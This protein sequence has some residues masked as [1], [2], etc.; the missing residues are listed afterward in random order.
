LW[1]VVGLGNPGKYY[2]NTRHNA[3]FTFVKQIARSWNVKLRKKKYLA[4]TAEVEKEN[5]KVLL[6]L[7]Q[8]YMNRSGYSVREV[9]DGTGISPEQLIV[10]YDDLDIPLGEIRIRKEGGPGTHKGMDSIIQEIQT[11][12]FPRIR[13]GIGPL[14]PEWDAAKFVLSPFEEG[15]K[16]LL[17]QSLK[18][19]QEA[20]ELI[21]ARKIDKAMNSYNQKGLA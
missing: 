14:P 12:A 1:A 2:A 16:A 15:E 13:V 19:A 21:L 10:V 20:L 4:K 11:I 8:T 18:K 7:P 5:E 17:E 3:G 9:L 6:A